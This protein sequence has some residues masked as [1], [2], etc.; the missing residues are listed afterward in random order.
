[1]TAS[2]SPFLDVTLLRLFDWL[3]RENLVREGQ[4][5]AVTRDEEPVS[6]RAGSL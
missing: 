4:S 2:K 3:K 1:M 5:Y 6:Q